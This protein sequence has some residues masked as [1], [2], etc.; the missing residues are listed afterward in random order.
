M[1]GSE[2]LAL[3]RSVQQATGSLQHL[4]IDISLPLFP[5]GQEGL[6]RLRKY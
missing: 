5:D 4:P 6:E 1:N 2:L 3:L